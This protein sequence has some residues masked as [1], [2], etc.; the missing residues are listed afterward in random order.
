M[1][2]GSMAL[3]SCGDS[4]KDEE[5]ASVVNVEKGA[6]SPMW[7]SEGEGAPMMEP[8]AP[9]EE[10]TGEVEEAPAIEEE[11]PE[12]KAEEPKTQKPAESA[13]GETSE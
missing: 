1:A 10:P 4:Q 9:A 3:S 11:A 6:A 13:S 2:L 12:T 8:Q 7:T 5:N